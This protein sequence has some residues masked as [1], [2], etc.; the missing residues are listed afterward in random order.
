MNI[1][2]LTPALCLLTALL[3]PAPAFACPANLPDPL[4][5]QRRNNPNRCEG[6]TRTNISANLTL[7]SFTTSTPTNTPNLTLTIPSTSTAPN[8]IIRS[9]ARRYQIDSFTPQRNNQGYQFTLPTQLMRNAQVPLDSLRM[10]A[11]TS[12][13][14]P[15]YIP[16]T[17]GSPSSRYQIVFYSPTLATIQSLE[18]LR[19]NQVIHRETRTTSRQGEIIFTWDGR[20]RPAGRYQIRIVGT[21]EQRGMRPQSFNRVLPFNHHPNWLR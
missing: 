14:Q 4:L 17:I 19:N 5:Y 1:K 16:V 7:V 8:L 9:Y 13:S 15:V 11:S 20:N 10:I 21:L 2:T 6:L 18:I 3:L 12:D